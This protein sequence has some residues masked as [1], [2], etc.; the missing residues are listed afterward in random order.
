MKLYYQEQEITVIELF[1]YYIIA[2]VNQTGEI[3]TLNV[4]DLDS[5]ECDTIESNIIS[6]EGY[7]QCLKRKTKPLRQKRAKSL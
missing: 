3:L 6:L 4:W 1:Q 5:D 2:Q 7:K